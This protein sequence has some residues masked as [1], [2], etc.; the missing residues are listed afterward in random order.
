VKEQTVLR[1]TATGAELAIRL[2]PLPRE[3]VITTDRGPDG[4]CRAIAR[5]TVA[6]VQGAELVSAF[7]KL[8]RAMSVDYVEI[9]GKHPKTGEPLTERL[10]P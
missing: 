8:K 7:V 9:Y 2:K 4:K 10:N 6:G 1:K 3:L 5:A